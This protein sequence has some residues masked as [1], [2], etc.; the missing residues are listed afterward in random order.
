VS[1][2]DAKSLKSYLAMKLVIA[3]YRRFSPR[4]LVH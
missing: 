3:P 1:S 4:S 2:V